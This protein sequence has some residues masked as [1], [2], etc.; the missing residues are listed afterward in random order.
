[1]LRVLLAKDLRRAW[2]NPLPWLLNL[3]LP[4]SVTALVGLAFGGKSDS[5]A[6]G[7]IRFA[8]VDEDDTPLT[9]LLRGAA[10]QGEG[11]KYLEPV[12]LGREAALGELNADKL[13]AVLIIP[14]NF[15]SHYLLGREHVSLELIKNPAQSIHPAVL[16]ELFGALVTGL[17]A[18]ARNFQSEFPDWQAVFKGKSDYREVA[19]LIERSGDKLKA[20]KDYVNPPLV[21]YTREVKTDASRPA[22][23]ADGQAKGGSR[24]RGSSPNVFGYLLGGMSAMFLLFIAS[25]GMTD[26]HRE[27][28][29]RTFQRYH[30]LQHALLPFVA[31]KVV[32]AVVLL[33][34]SSLVLL[35]G[36]ALIFR[37]PWQ[38][39]FALIILTL[40]YACFAAGFM[41]VL[42]ALADDERI[43]NTL[44][45]IVAMALAIA[46][47]C[48]F[49][50]QQLPAFLREHIS[51]LLPTY[52]FTETVRSLEFGSGEVAWV[53]VLLKLAGLSVALI[54]VAALLFRRRFRRRLWT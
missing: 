49:P 45:T 51:P 31:G 35:G 21:S 8:I 36:G 2:R 43:A 19:R 33:L 48:A 29:H 44:N 28:R 30:T 25:T 3:A 34:L 38:H 7:R 1:M 46:G 27:V 41:A 32:F 18:L 39:P 9:G 26:L 13:S 10:S 54:G 15:M 42:T 5:G 6:L 17:N 40:G 47:G 22:E 53:T 23:P 20:A 11:S 37:I 16:E 50:A 52:W 24:R 12:F 4:L 14:T